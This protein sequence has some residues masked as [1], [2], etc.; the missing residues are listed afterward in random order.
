MRAPT[1]QQRRE[2][3]GRQDRLLE[4]RAVQDDGRPAVAVDGDLER[5][6]LGLAT[7]EPLAGLDAHLGERGRA[8]FGNDAGRLDV[9]RDG[10]VRVESRDGRVEL[11][12]AA[13]VDGEVVRGARAAP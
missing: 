9:E 3:P 12:V 1:Q 6:G 11:C 10:P 5:A 8:C 7:P 4:H 13:V 2:E